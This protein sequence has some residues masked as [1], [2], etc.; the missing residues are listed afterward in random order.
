MND[1]THFTD[2][3]ADLSSVANERPAEPLSPLASAAGDSP[4]K[5]APEESPLPAPITYTLKA[6]AARLGIPAKRL[7]ALREEHLAPADYVDGHLTAAGYAALTVAL[8]LATAEKPAEKP[9]PTLL[10]QA[11]VFRHPLN[12]HLIEAK[13]LDNGEQILICVA[14][15]QDWRGG[16][17]L[18]CVKETPP[19]RLYVLS[20]KQDRRHMPDGR[21]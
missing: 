11:R 16:M 12:R 17:V 3:G 18:T 2:G 19:S 21:S 5:I 14:N 8:G 20:G 9:A 10:V 15:N 1:C 6:A 7:R 4:L 13:R